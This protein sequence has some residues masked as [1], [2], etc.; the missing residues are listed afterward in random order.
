MIIKLSCVLFINFKI[1]SKMKNKPLKYQQLLR[2]IS[3]S[4]TGRHIISYGYAISS[5]TFATQT[6]TKKPNHKIN[7]S[8]LKN[9]QGT[10]GTR[11][12]TYSSIKP[13]LYGPYPIGSWADVARTLFFNSP[14][15]TFTDSRQKQRDSRWL[16]TSKGP[17]N[18]T[19][20]I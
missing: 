18:N 10:N 5:S 8:E 1:Y 16:L 9:H 6:G 20:G 11:E 7:G 3:L 2:P 17:L 19:V 4:V 12:Q 14:Q 13:V 15:F